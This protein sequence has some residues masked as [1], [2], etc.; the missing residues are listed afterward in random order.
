MG[1]VYSTKE[2]KSAGS[3]SAYKFSTSCSLNT[4]PNLS[5]HTV[6]I[7]GI[8]SMARIWSIFNIPIG[9]LASSIVTS[10]PAFLKISI[11][12]FTGAKQPKSTVVPAQSNSTPSILLIFSTL[13]CIL[14]YYYIILE[15]LLHRSHQC[16]QFGMYLHPLTSLD[17]S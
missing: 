9:A 7:L 15:Y 4:L 16:Y 3:N 11:N 13:P 2:D 12:T 10:T 8:D 17:R 1:S 5:S 14:R 6:E